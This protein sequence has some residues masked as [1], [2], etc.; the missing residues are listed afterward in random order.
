LDM[1]GWEYTTN[2]ASCVF[3]TV[4]LLATVD[5]NKLNDKSRVLL[6]N[7]L[8]HG[9]IWF[10]KLKGHW[11]AFVQFKKASGELNTASGNTSRHRGGYNMAMAAYQ[12]HGWAT[13]CDSSDKCWICKK[14]GFQKET[15]SL[16]HLALTYLGS[17]LYGDDDYGVDTPASP[18]FAAVLDACLG[19]TTVYEV[20]PFLRT[21]END[22]GKFLQ[23]EYMEH[24]G[25]IVTTRDRKRVI[26]KL[27]LM[28]RGR[29]AM[30]AAIISAC[31]EIGYD[32]EMNDMLT[33]LFYRIRDEE[34]EEDIEEEV[35]SFGVRGEG[36]CLGR[37]PTVNEVLLA[38][39]GFYNPMITLQRQLEHDHRF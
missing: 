12:R 32:P 14:T 4:S 9:H 8:A 23:V 7:T 17:T 2:E 21:S 35:D 13:A 6:A 20:K 31:Y 30:L 10:L 11:G 5:I 28:P 18:Y 22:G 34:N 16:P 33:D 39:D 1:K 38:Q 24:E 27:C 25:K 37:P 36:A 26:A 3:E 19:T 29:T 15:Y